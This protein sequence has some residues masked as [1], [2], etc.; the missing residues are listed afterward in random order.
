MTTAQSVLIF[1][2]LNFFNFSN[3]ATRYP[4]PLQI[5]EKTVNIVKQDFYDPTFR[6]VDW[7]YWVEEHRSKLSSRSTENELKDNLNNLLSVLKA[8][9]T[10]FLSDSDQEY[11][12]IKSVFSG[13]LNGYP[14]WQI[15]AWFEKI[16]QEHWF[17]RNVF[18]GSPAHEA[19]IVPGDEVMEADGEPFHPIKSFRNGGP[20][21]L[22][23]ERVSNQKIIQILVTPVL[24]STQRAMLRGSNASFRIFPEGKKRVAYYHLWAGTHDEFKESLKNAVYRARVA[25]VFILDLRD[26]FGGAYPEYL[27]P[28]F[29]KDNQPAVY[30]KPLIVLINDGVRSGKEWLAHI[31]KQTRR[32]VLFG[33]KTKG[34]FLNGKP[35]DIWPDR[36]LLYLAVGEDPKMPKLEGVGVPPD[37]NV[38]YSYPYSEGRDPVLEAAIKFS[39]KL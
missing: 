36:Y 20:V 3:A 39:R 29:P 18:F 14:V 17:V 25:D 23:I 31:L 4:D 6:G 1:L 7:N 26:G 32:A 22:A 10:E 12:A 28:F 34:Y 21:R 13:D 16:G 37:Y 5:F 33:T 35:Y 24:E 27:E 2:I 11:W 19:G 15:G 8:S 30:D 9:H 38:H